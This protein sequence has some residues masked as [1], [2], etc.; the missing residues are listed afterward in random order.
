MCNQEY[1]TKYQLLK[2]SRS[3]EEQAKNHWLSGLEYRG[4]KWLLGGGWEGGLLI[5]PYPLKVQAC[6]PRDQRPSRVSGQRVVIRGWGEGEG[7][8]LICPYPLKVQ[9]CHSTRPSRVSGQKVVIG[10]RGRGEGEGELLICPYPL[11][12]Q[13][14]PPQDQRTAL[15]SSVLGQEVV[16]GGGGGE[17]ELLICPYPLN[18]QACPPRDHRPALRSRVSG[19]EVVIGLLMLHLYQSLV[20]FTAQFLFT[21]ASRLSYPLDV[22]LIDFFKC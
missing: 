6:P 15:R 19:Q 12:V 16:I 4:R 7:E 18:V 20:H 10:G 2:Q 3:G 8:L 22:T 13:A 5:C 21:I 9:A 17:G 11:K 1:P 14:C